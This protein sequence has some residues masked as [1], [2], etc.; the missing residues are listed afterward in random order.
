LFYQCFCS[1]A[2]DFQGIFSSYLAPL[3]NHID[4]HRASA[5]QL[6]RQNGPQRTS[7]MRIQPT[8]A[9]ESKTVA[10]ATVFENLRRS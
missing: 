7:E 10:G 3:S 8:T 1:N 4:A 5:G 9:P 2:A 6:E